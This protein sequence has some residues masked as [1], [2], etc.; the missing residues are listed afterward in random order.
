MDSTVE[1]S[2][3]EQTVT[4]SEK[5]DSVDSKHDSTD[6]ASVPNSVLPNRTEATSSLFSNIGEANI[7]G[8]GDLDQLE[9]KKTEE[10]DKDNKEGEKTEE[11]KE[12]EDE[13]MEQEVTESQDETEEEEDMTTEELD[14]VKNFHADSSKISSPV[15]VTTSASKAEDYNPYSTD[16][17]QEEDMDVDNS[18]EAGPEGTAND[19][20]STSMQQAAQEVAKYEA[21]PEFADDVEDQEDQVL[22]YSPM[23]LYEF[24]SCTTK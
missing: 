9:A 19:D 3:L 16:N 7:P 6:S 14:I 13:K 4:N 15:K 21:Q 11:G 8:L 20:L 24:S 10:K 17:S 2:I 23:G 18:S 5:T 12:K 22:K 1:S